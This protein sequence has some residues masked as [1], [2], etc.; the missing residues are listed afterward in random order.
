MGST[1]DGRGAKEG[2]AVWKEGD[3]SRSNVKLST[4]NLNLQAEE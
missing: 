2:V 3:F 1:R 4:V